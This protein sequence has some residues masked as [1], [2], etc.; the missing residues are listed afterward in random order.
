MKEMMIRL[1][2]IEMAAAEDAWLAKHYPKSGRY[3]IRRDNGDVTIADVQMNELPVGE[4]RPIDERLTHLFE[5]FIGQPDLLDPDEWAL[6]ID[7]ENIKSAA[8]AETRAAK[9]QYEA[10]ER[11]LQE[12]MDTDLAMRQLKLDEEYKR[13]ELLLELETPKRF[14]QGE[15]VSVLP[16]TEIIK[17]LAGKK[18]E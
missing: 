9:E 5:T 8:Q 1:P 2:M 3:I 10:R 14:S 16:L 15:W 18:E 12:K 7:I 13:K 6:A 11:S 17:T 4:V